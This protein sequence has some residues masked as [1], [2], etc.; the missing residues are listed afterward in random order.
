MEVGRYYNFY[1]FDGWYYG[2]LYWDGHYA[3][4]QRQ[5]AYLIR[6]R[7]LEGARAQ[8]P[9]R[10]E[11]QRRDVNS[12]RLIVPGHQWE[13]VKRLNAGLPAN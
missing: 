10:L 12:G 1:Y 4:E 11:E 6:S 13:P 7:T 8:I 9:E 3:R 2:V 5:Y